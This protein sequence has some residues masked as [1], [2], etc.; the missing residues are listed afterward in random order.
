MELFDIRPINPPFSQMTKFRINENLRAFVKGSSFSLIKKEFF[1][2]ESRNHVQLP[3]LRDHSRNLRRRKLFSTVPSNLRTSPV[4]LPYR[5]LSDDSAVPK[6][7]AEP[8]P[9]SSKVFG[10]ATRS[11]LHRIGQTAWRSRANRFEGRTDLRF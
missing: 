5:I 7:R 2:N 3:R 8:W 9:R 6:I 11:T 4:R 1:L 10:C